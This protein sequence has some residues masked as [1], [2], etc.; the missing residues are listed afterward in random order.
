MIHQ[1]SFLSN[2]NQIWEE[3]HFSESLNT[4]VNQNAVHL[5]KSLSHT[6]ILCVTKK[7]L[8]KVVLDL[9]KRVSI[10]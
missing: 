8:Y 10:C 9:H 2:D 6:K 7:N 5:S 4:S 1:Q 3:S